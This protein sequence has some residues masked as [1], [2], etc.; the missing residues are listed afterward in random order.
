MPP[1]CARKPRDSCSRVALTGADLITTGDE[2][3]ASCGPPACALSPVVACIHGMVSG[4]KSP[5]SIHRAD[6]LG[7]LGGS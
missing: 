4:A 3:A 7:M 6:G 2:S 1:E 5:H